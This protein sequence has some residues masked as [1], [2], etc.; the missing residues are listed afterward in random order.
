MEAVDENWE[1]GAWVRQIWIWGMETGKVLRRWEIGDGA[2]A[3]SRTKPPRGNI[4]GTAKYVLGIFGS[5]I[6]HR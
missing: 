5:C 1:T 6:Y 4:S 3:L 2:T